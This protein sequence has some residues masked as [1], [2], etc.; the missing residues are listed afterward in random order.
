[1]ARQRT[2]LRRLLKDRER[3]AAALQREDARPWRYGALIRR[4]PRFVV[5]CAQQAA[6]IDVALAKARRAT[7]RMA[8]KGVAVTGDWVRQVLRRAYKGW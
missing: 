1:M 7:A 3:K 2:P 4:E 8:E 6:R 5:R